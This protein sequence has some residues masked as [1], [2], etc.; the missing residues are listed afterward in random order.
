LLTPE[1][2]YEVARVVNREV[3]AYLAG[4]VKPGEARKKR[5]SKL[6]LMVRQ[7]AL[8]LECLSDAGFVKGN[9]RS[10]VQMQRHI[11]LRVPHSI[12]ADEHKS[13]SQ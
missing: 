8:A 13:K 2:R 10:Q 5:E 12:V 4:K 6:S 1:F 7:T 3:V 9:L 11:G